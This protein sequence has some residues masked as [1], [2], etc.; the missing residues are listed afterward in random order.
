MATRT[1]YT[2]TITV[3]VY[4][5]WKC[6][7]CGEV[8]FA[9]GVIRCQK[10]ESTT[11][12]RNSKHEEAKALAKKQV[13]EEW[14]EY[15]FKIIDDPNHSGSAMFYNFFLQNTKCTQCG[16]KPR[17]NKN[18]K[19]IPLAGLVITAGIIS[20]IVSFSTGSS[21][22]SW[23]IFLSC[24]GFLAW[25]IVREESYK[26]MMTKLSKENTPVIGS[27]NPELI[28]FANAL[29]KTIPNPDKIIEIVKGFDHVPNTTIN[30]AP[31]TENNDSTVTSNFCR[32]C[33][34]KLQAD[35]GFCHKC[36]TEVVK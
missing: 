35:S 4:A 12:L 10:E 5:G 30:K 6:E 3:P 34:A 19:F 9:E 33:G 21:V 13:Q 20:G 25:L 11:S 8:N 29:G 24:I 7:H 32:K 18:A 16:K 22:A 15:A 31:I 17:W 36:G 28:N 23:L 1:T 26:K 2:S 14:A 27:L